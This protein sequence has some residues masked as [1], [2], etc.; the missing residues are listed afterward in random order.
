ME[1][2]LAVDQGYADAFNTYNSEANKTMSEFN[3]AMNQ[4]MSA[5]YGGIGEMNDAGSQLSQMLMGVG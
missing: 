1:Y 5:I 2:N 3:Q 4:E